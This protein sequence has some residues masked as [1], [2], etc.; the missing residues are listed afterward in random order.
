[1]ISQQ[2]NYFDGA[3]YE[4]VIETVSSHST[5]ILREGTTKHWCLYYGD[6]LLR[7]LPAIDYIANVNE[8]LFLEPNG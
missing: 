1:M 8:L 4:N 6:C 7:G 2:N 5:D 3:S